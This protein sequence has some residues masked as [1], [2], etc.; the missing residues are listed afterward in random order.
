LQVNSTPPGAQIWLDAESTGFVTNHRFEDIYAGV[1]LV[2]LKFPVFGWE[3]TV[4]LQKDET[5]T[6]TASV[7]NVVWTREVFYASAPAVAE[8]GTVYLVQYD[9]L[10]AFAPD[11]SPKWQA[12]LGGDEVEAYP[13]VGPDGTIYVRTHNYLN[14]F[15]PDGTLNWQCSPPSEPGWYDPANTCGL[16]IGEDGTVYTGSDGYLCAILPDSTLLWNVRLEVFSPPVIGSDGTI[17]VQDRDGVCAL[18]ANGEERWHF[19]SEWAS[20]VEALLALGPDGTV[21]STTRDRVYAIDANGHLKWD[22]HTAMPYSGHAGGAAVDDAGTSYFTM[23]DTLYAVSFDGRVLWRRGGYDSYAYNL[24][25]PTISE[26]GTVY[27]VS[28]KY[29]SLAA[30]SDQ[31]NLRW[32]FLTDY[33]YQWSSATLDRDSLL[34][35]VGDNRLWVLEVGG[36]P[37]GFWPMY[38]HDSRHTGRAGAP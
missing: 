5:R 15:A 12:G 26:D 17:Y 11:G 24:T 9:S 18:T 8:D 7:P 1:H 32:H 35:V 22:V 31:G 30:V 36:G 2:A 37:R 28:S 27:A 38:Q 25:V 16:A 23:N 19:E 14:S 33:G 4:W 21:I 20:E 13:A 3:D 10:L 34:R 6:L 29:A